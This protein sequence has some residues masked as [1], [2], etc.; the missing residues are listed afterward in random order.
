MILQLLLFPFAAIYITDL[1]KDLLKRYFMVP[2]YNKKVYPTTVRLFP[3][4]NNSTLDYVKAMSKVGY[5]GKYDI[6]PDNVVLSSALA[7]E[8]LSHPQI[9]F[10]TFKGRYQVQ[11]LLKNH[12]KDYLDR[13]Q[14]QI[15]LKTA[16]NRKYINEVICADIKSFN[17]LIDLYIKENGIHCS[18]NKVYIPDLIEF[19]VSVIGENACLRVLGD[20][21]AKDKK[22]RTII[23]RTTRQTFLIRF[24]KLRPIKYLRHIYRNRMQ[25]RSIGKMADILKNELQLNDGSIK[26]PTNMNALWIILNQKAVSI[27]RNPFRLSWV[28]MNLIRCMVSISC[29]R[30][31]NVLVNISSDASSSQELINEQ[32]VLISNYGRDITYPLLP[33]MKRLIW[34]VKRALLES[35]PA[36]C[37][38]RK[39]EHDMYLSNGMVLSK[40]SIVSLDLFSHYHKEKLYDSNIN[41]D[42]LLW[43][44]GESRCS[45][46][47]YSFAQ[48]MAFTAI[49]IRNFSMLLSDDGFIG[50]HPGYEQISTVV[51]KANSLFLEKHYL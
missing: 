47:E 28:L 14:G 46:S 25:I 31:A 16:F 18:E 4:E 17:N 1:C 11:N 23:E 3:K 35:S 50:R 34:F 24:S 36:S 42:D 38:H 9:S 20:E 40:G 22:V 21:L 32:A 12:E 33:K 26:S 15:E 43:G 41:Y 48:I 13:H 45:F 10:S 39:V 37:M 2:P 19:V 49:M 29:T 51:P 7:T 30:I 6:L 8:F 27:R 5:V 44:F